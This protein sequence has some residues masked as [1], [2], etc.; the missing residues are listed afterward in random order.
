VKA[1]LLAAGL[2]TRLRSLTRDVPKCLLP[3]SGQPLLTYW[4]RA[5]ERA[6]VSEALINLHYH[7]DSV[8][9]YLAKLDT[10]IR[11]TTFFEPELLG[12]AGTLREAWD[13]VADETDFFVIYADNLARV[14]LRRLYSFHESVGRPALSLLA[15]LTDQPERCGILELAGD[16][17]V[18]SFEEKPAHPRSNFA[19]AGIHVANTALREHL[20]QKTPA[21]LGFDVLPRLIGRMH[22]YVTDEY[23]QDIGTPETYAAAQREWRMGE[24]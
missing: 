3:I 8:R 17:R 22:A 11:V 23:I 18:L 1:I 9:D 20:P 2:G 15:Y 5:L 21:D 4:F 6:G 19:N 13:F 7:A 12:S 24:R 10:P 16:G 14:D